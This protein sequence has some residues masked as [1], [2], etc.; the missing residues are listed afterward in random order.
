MM[1]PMKLFMI[2]LLFGTCCIGGKDRDW[3]TGRVLDSQS[4][5][6][7]VQTGARTTATTNGTVSPDYGAGSTVNASTTANTRVDQTAIQDTQLWIVGKEYGYLVNDSVQKAVGLPTHGIITRSIAN[8]KHGCRF[9][10]G[11]EIKY[12]QEKGKLFAIDADGREYKLD[13]VRQERLQH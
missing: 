4:G 6:I 7:Y 10:V 9:V 2:L 3:Q 1:S 13:I 12:S 8:R 11:D 5:R